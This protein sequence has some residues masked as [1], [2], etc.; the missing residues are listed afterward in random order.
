MSSSYFLASS[1]YLLGLLSIWDFLDFNEGLTTLFLE[2]WDETIEP[3][4]FPPK[5]PDFLS[6][7]ASDILS[8]LEFVEI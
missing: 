4:D 3:V 5:F 8:S 1:V 7:D 6:T 2:L